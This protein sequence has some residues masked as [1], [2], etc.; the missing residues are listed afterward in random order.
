MNKRIL[1]CVCVFAIRKMMIS[2]WV[3]SIR[4]REGERN[5]GEK[6][7]KKKRR[8]KTFSIDGLEKW[9]GNEA[10]DDRK[11]KETIRDKQELAWLWHQRREW[12]MLERAKL[13]DE[14]ATCSLLK[15]FVVFLLK[16]ELVAGGRNQHSANQTGTHPCYTCIEPLV[17]YSRFFSAQP[18]SSANDRTSMDLLFLLADH[19]GS[20]KYLNISSL[21]SSS[22]IKSCDQ[23]VS[24]WTNEFECRKVVVSFRSIETFL[25]RDCV[26][27]GTCS[28]QDKTQSMNTTPVSNCVY[29]DERSQKLECIYCCDT[30]LCNRTTSTRLTSS[31]LVI[32]FIICQWNFRQHW[33]E[34]KRQIRSSR[35]LSK[36][37]Y[38]CS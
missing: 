22:F 10:N 19:A 14:I 24:G 1:L 7:K 30:P 26:P 28:W 11:K 36:H 25:R 3:L 27:K 23:P 32:V 34:K 13:L 21:S 29:T 37:A 38:F 2:A 5:D 8:E 16:L 17:G 9:N 12:T 35:H 6:K 15:L 31:L 20:C 18:S 4:R 33:E